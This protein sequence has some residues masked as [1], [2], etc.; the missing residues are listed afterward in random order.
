MMKIR[1]F[2]DTD[3]LY[4]VFADREVTET[5]DLNENTVIDLDS[6][7]NIVAITLEHAREYADV[8]DVSFRQIITVPE[9]AT[10]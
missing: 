2:A 3:T 8:F 4:V 7:G 1:Y 9:H 5:Q 6:S 10:P